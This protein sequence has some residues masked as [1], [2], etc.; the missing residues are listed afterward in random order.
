MEMSGNVWER[1][2]TTG[3]ASGAAYTG[4]LG[5]G[6]LTQLGDANVATWPAPSTA[7]GSGLRG[8]GYYNNSPNASRTSDRT[9]ASSASAIRNQT[10]GG[11]GVR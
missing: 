2:I 4:A 7:V 8:N 6:E 5:D 3:N 1:I 9:S 10:Y 11:R